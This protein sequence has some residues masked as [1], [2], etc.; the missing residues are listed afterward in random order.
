M[1]IS[2]TNEYNGI[3]EITNRINNNPMIK[4]A[5]NRT[6]ISMPITRKSSLKYGLSDKIASSGVTTRSAL[7][8]RCSITTRRTLTKNKINQKSTHSKIYKNQEYCERIVS[9]AKNRLILRK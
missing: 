5:S 8:N 7:D 3:V 1:H 4:S 6:I 2:N 9:F